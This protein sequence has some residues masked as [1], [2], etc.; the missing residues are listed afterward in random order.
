MI[1]ASLKEISAKSTCKRSNLS[2]VNYEP[3]H[4][5]FELTSFT[6]AP[7]EGEGF[8]RDKLDAVADRAA[9][10]LTA[11]NIGDDFDIQVRSI[12]SKTYVSVKEVKALKAVVDRAQGNK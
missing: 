11:L 10:A 12:N 6:E 7:Q 5:S 3:Y 4:Q 8:V 1:L 9:E 2:L